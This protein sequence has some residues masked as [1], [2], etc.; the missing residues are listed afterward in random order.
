MNYR[1]EDLLKAVRSLSCA[2]CSHPPRVQAAHSNLIEHGKGMRI[3]AHDYAIMAL[4]G[5][6]QNR[7]HFEL[8]NGNKMSKTER[9]L[10]TYE[11]IAK[12]YM[13]LMAQGKLKVVI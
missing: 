7:C 2:H 10:F 8:D 6:N 12:T 5:E 13:A 9:R 3:K 1:N 11:M 4:C